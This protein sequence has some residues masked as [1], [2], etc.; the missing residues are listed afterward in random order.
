MKK[1]I[2]RETLLSYPDF[3]QPFDIHTDA[4][5]TQMG[6]V[7]SQNNKPIA[8]YSRKLNSAQ[9]NYTTTEKELLAIVETLKAFRNILLGQSITVYT[10]HKNLTYKH[11]NTERVMR[12]RLILEEFG[13]TLKYVPGET[14]IVADAL[15]RLELSETQLDAFATAELLG[16][17]KNEI[18][19]D[20]HPVSYRLIDKEQQKDK[21][22][23]KRLRND[24]P[25]YSVTSFRGGGKTRDLVTYNGKIVVPRSMQRRLV[26][27]YH[28]QL[29]HPG[30]TRTE[31]SLKQ[32]FY[33]PNLRQEVHR[34]VKKCH[35]CQTNKRHKTK[36]GHLPAKEA[37]ADPW[38]KLC[39]NLIGPY[40]IKRKAKTPLTLW[41]VT[42]ID[43]ATGWF[44]VKQIKDKQAITVANVVE[45]TWLCRYPWPTQINYDQGTEFMAEFAQMIK[46][47]YGIK[48][49]PSTT[50]NPQSNSVIERIHQ[51]LGNIIRVYDYDALDEADPWSGP[52]SA[53]MFALRATYHTT[54]QASPAQLVFG[55]D[56]IL[57]TQFEADWQLI[58]NR[59]QRIINANNK[60]E[61]SK[62]IEHN[63]K[64]DDLV[65]YHVPSKSKFG[66]PEYKGPY[67]I[68]TVGTNGTVWLKMGPLTETVNIRNVRPYST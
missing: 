40:T 42:M 36:Y 26:E 33:W 47:D 37:E 54:L 1:I 21:E 49:R 57:N 13:P 32:H 44:E 51:T 20:A 25:G 31:Q 8:F 14:N 23:M 27:W 2:S 43:P 68:K 53:A 12:W 19:T 64:V 18:P 9:R 24:S 15:S 6:A 61:N 45:Q 16:Y 39:V 46:D 55:R 29:C 11:F 67:K 52:L 58:K 65:L 3:N 66:P 60:R 10:D 22:I 35:I 4:S 59:K 30:E 48:L 5:K 34:Q 50:R 56:A 28:L 41:C 63:Y 17:S 62:R 38:D 7:I